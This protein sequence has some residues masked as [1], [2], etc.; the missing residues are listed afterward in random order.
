MPIIDIFT[1][2]GHTKEKV[3]DETAKAYKQFEKQNKE[4]KR[5]KTEY[6]CG[7]KERQRHPR[8]SINTSLQNEGYSPDLDDDHDQ[9]NNL[10]EQFDLA[11]RVQ[12][13]IKELPTRQKE[14]VQFFLRGFTEAQIARRLGISKPAINK[15]KNKLKDKF[16]DLFDIGG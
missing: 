14:V 8:V 16:K 12:A 4:Y 7:K 1:K 15:L 6:E 13:R 9:W 3:T 5:F 11:S 2:D 10:L